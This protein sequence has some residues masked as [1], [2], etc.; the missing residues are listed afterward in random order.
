MMNLVDLSHP[1]DP[2][3][4]SIP[5]GLP[6]LTCCPIATVPKDGYSM[7]AVSFGSHTGTHIDAPSHFIA[8]GKTIDQI[9]LNALVGHAL[10][11]DLTHK[12][13]QEI[14]TWND[15]SQNPH[16]EKIEPG[17]ILLLHTGWSKHWGSDQQIYWDHPYLSPDVADKLIASGISVIGIDCASPD[18]SQLEPPWDFPFHHAFLGRGGFIVENLTALEE[19]QGP[20]VTVNL[21]PINL[22][23]CDGAPVRGIAW[24]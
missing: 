24:N 11:L 17:I 16:A 19:L 6:Q 20:T 10:V 4:M 15:I 21:L 18:K 8:D 1:L 22:V 13:P 7:H 3:H 2:E 5:P 12:G 23:G 9:P 14:I